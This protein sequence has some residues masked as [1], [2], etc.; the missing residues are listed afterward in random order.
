MCLLR[1]FCGRVTLRIQLVN[2]Y[3]LEDGVVE[4]ASPDEERFL[5]THA[6]EY[7]IRFDKSLGQGQVATLLVFT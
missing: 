7:L 1:T 5:A 2:V 4:A 6:R 3:Y